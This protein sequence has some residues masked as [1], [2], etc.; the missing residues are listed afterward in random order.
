M[1][2]LCDSNVFISRDEAMHADF[3]IHLITILLIKPSKEKIREIFLSAL[4][5]E[6]NL[7]LSHYL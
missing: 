7:L 2:G 3:A 1:P 5:I 4:V 6:K